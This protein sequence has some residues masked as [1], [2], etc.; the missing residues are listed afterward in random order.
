[1]IAIRRPAPLPELAAMMA[2][3]SPPALVAKA[4]AFAL[5]S[6]HL[7]LTRSWGVWEGETCLACAGL[8]DDGPGRLEAWFACTPRA[9]RRIVAIVRAARLT[10]DTIVE[11]ERVE[12]RARVAVGWEPGRRLASLLGFRSPRAAAGVEIWIKEGPCPTSSRD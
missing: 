1:M 7:A 12:I 2:A 8:A 11:T 9:A 6:R 5:A 10:L 3:L 4:G